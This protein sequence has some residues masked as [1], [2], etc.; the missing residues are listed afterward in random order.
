MT[1]NLTCT[2]NVGKPAGKFVWTQYRGS[3]PYPQGDVTTTAQQI[4]GTCISNGTS[5]LSVQV[6]AE[7]NNAVFRC[8]VEQELA[9]QTIYT[10]T[11]PNDFNVYCKLKFFY[12]I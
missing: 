7:D 11:L 5:I 10:Q 3:T 2:G 9:D 6:Q 8:Q 4:P 1:I 12:N